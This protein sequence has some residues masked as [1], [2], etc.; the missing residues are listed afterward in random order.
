MFDYDR[1]EAKIKCIH[2]HI[3][4]YLNKIEHNLNKAKENAIEI[5]GK[6]NS[7]DPVKELR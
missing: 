7:L 1:H 4:M 6:L 2:D 3:Y 5:G